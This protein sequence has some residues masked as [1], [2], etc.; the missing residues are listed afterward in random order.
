MLKIALEL[1]WMKS[2]LTTT[3]VKEELYMVTKYIIEE[4]SYHHSKPGI[5]PTVSFY[6]CKILGVDC[7]CKNKTRALR[8]DTEEAATQEMLRLDAWQQPHN[9][10]HYTF[11]IIPVRCRA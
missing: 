8:F 11:R 7:F 10:P 6:E 1:L 3:A 4:T 5:G 9:P 2:F